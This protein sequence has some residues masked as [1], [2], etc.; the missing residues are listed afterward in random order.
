MVGRAS[1]GGW[2]SDSAGALARVAER[3]AQDT[4]VMKVQTSPFERAAEAYSISAGGH[5]RGKLVLVP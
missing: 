3:R 5:V 4:L 2:G 1:G